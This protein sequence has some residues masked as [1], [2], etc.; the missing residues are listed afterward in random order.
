MAEKKIF[1]KRV[2]AMAEI[3]KKVVF[4]GIQNSEK[5]VVYMP[6]IV[7]QTAW[8][9][10]PFFENFSCPPARHE[11]MCVWGE[12]ADL[13]QNRAAP[14]GGRYFLVGAC[15]RSFIGQASKHLSFQCLLRPCFFSFRQKRD[16]WGLRYTSEPKISK[17]DQNH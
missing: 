5:K 7:M 6:E 13:F 11:K 9:K 12:N 8:E 10:S 15:A 17:I 4:F 2:V 14:R 3:P 1:L 16:L